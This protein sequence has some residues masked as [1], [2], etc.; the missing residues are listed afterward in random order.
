MSTAIRILVLVGSITVYVLSY[1]F[2]SKL[3]LVGN[4]NVVKKI[5]KVLFVC[6]GSLAI[7]ALLFINPDEEIF[8]S[9]NRIKRFSTLFMIMGLSLLL[10]CFIAYL[11]AGNVTVKS[12]FALVMI[13]IAIVTW[14][15]LAIKMDI[16]ERIEKVNQIES[17]ERIEPYTTQ[18]LKTIILECDE[19]GKIYSCKYEYVNGNSMISDEISGKDIKD[20]AYIKNENSYIELTKISTDYINKEMKPKAKGYSYTE[21]EERYTLYLN[22]SQTTVKY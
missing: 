5:I 21:T 2:V 1:V 18:E 20:V 14:I 22:E 15:T 13:I 9:S 6:L 19:D 8:L 4:Y 16:P 7:F 12:V 11:D 17:Y 3:K 10:T